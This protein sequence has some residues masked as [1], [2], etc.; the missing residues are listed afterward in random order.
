V[1]E[2]IVT[3]FRRKWL[4]SAP[5]RGGAISG[6]AGALM[7]LLAA[8][9]LLG[10]GSRGDIAS[11]MILRPLSVLILGYGLSRITWQQIRANAFLFG[12]ASAI[13]GLTL[14]QLVP[15]P[16][17]LWTRLPGHEI[18]V[19]LD[20]IAQWPIPWRALSLTP[21]ATWNALW[22]QAGPL[23]VLVLGVQLTREE[24]A[25]SI[26]LIL[27][28]GLACALLGTAQLLADGQSP[29]YFYATTNNGSLVGL[30]ANRN[31]QAIL[32][33]ALIPI[34]VVRALDL[35]GAA[36]SRKPALLPQRPPLFLHRKVP[37]AIIITVSAAALLWVMILVSGARV[38]LAAAAIATLCIPLLRGSPH[39]TRTGLQEPIRMSG[40]A[41]TKS[42]LVLLALA[43][44]AALVALTFWL[45]RA[46]VIDRIAQA[47]PEDEMRL[48]I[49]PT[50]LAMIR[51]YAP[52]GS[53]LGSFEQVYQLHEPGSLLSASYMNHAHNDWLEVALTCGIPG[54][55]LLLL[56]VAA[57]GVRCLQAFGAA[58]RTDATAPLTRLGL[59]V[60]LLFALASLSD[61]PLR[62]PSL[63]CLF[64]LAAIWA[65]ARLLP[66]AKLHPGSVSHRSSRKS[67]SAASLIGKNAQN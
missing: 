21:T 46:V 13:L 20:R 63:S 45:D 67:A 12:F 61:Y 1:E 60:I 30:F 64:V 39:G 6:P 48:L 34:L 7:V 56:A 3:S 4:P 58:G 17:T 31:H 40:P 43:A 25:S 26:T 18:I 55:A 9:F 29:L 5:L 47:R 41:L 10:G 66:E 36:G 24:H 2:G 51:T 16:P 50:I 59:V 32:F 35:R 53:G 38:G 27:A 44:L 62:V 52:W 65:G 37:I 19:D 11:L 33:A 15:L 28:F 14:L 22:A 54:V 42:G 23:A 57:F 49:I 8:S